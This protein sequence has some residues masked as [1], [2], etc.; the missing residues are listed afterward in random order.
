MGIGTDIGV[1]TEAAEESEQEVG[2]QRT[3]VRFVYNHM[4]QP[5]QPLPPT[6]AALGIPSPVLCFVAVLATCSATRSSSSSS[7][8]GAWFE[9]AGELLQQ[10]AGGSVE[11]SAAWACLH[12]T[13]DRV[14]E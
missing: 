2:V 12:L 9:A 5:V 13:T 3:L 6:A 11:Q 14:S 8:C 10:P 7:N 1:R 4:A